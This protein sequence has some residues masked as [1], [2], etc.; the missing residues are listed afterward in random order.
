MKLNDIIKDKKTNKL[1]LVLISIISSSVLLLIINF[2]P[3]TIM[4]Y[5]S[6]WENKVEDFDTYK[7][8]F[9]NIANLAY[10]EFS[11]GQMMYSYISVNENPDGTVDLNYIDRNTE[12]SVEVK[13][14]QKEQESLEK[15]VAKAFHHGDGG[16]LDIIYVYKNQVEFVIATGQYSL[17]YRKD[18]HEPKFVNTEYT[19]GTFKIKKISDHWYHARF[20][21]D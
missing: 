5:T 9:Q 20:V 12:D 19:K 16:Y 11:K 2:L 15:I 8:D 4:W 14:S 18:G 10:R 21:E 7:D 1:K 17:V 3:G 6:L 13:M